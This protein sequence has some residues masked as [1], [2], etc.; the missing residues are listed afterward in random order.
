M[1]IKDIE[2]KEIDITQDDGALTKL[3]EHNRMSLPV[4]EMNGS[5]VDYDEF[6]DIL[7]LV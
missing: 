4:L 5:F 6:D 1:T 3:R 7:E 2:F